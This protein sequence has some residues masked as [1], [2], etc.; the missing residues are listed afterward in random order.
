MW[1][2]ALN[3]A[4][5]E[6]SSALRRAESVYYPLAICLSSSASSK[7]D[8]ASEVA[9]IGKDSPSKVSLSLSLSLLTTLSRRPSS[10]GL[11][12]K[13]QTQSREWPLMPLSPQLLLRTHPKRKR[14]PSRWRLS[15]Q[16]SLCLLRGTLRVRVKKPQRQHSPSPSGPQPK[17]K[18]Q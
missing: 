4:R 6:A 10:S 5:V 16:L 2:K 12:K 7:V 11:L 18:L 3:Q 14:Y 8:I 15:W 13:K 9:E 17:I 1:N